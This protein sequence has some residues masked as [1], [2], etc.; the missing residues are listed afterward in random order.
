MA[1]WT[2]MRRL[3]DTRGFSLVELL[4]ALAVF[5]LAVL[6]LMHMAAEGTRATM[7]VEERVFAGVVADNQA[8]E[9]TLAPVASLSS[10]AAGE[11]EAGDR[12]WSWRRTT[13]A[14]EQP[15]VVRVDITVAAPGSAQVVAERSL[16]RSVQ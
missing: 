13:R 5:G 4:V 2:S 11:S 9:A 7:L 1:G 15:G 3:P 10:P 16:L 14:T 12:D 6:G 8:V